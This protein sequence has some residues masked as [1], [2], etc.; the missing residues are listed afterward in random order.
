MST[1]RKLAELLDAATT[2]VPAGHLAPPLAAIHGRVR[3]RRRMFGAVAAAA[4]AVVLAGGYSVGQRMLAEPAPRVPVHPAASP[5]AASAP[6]V[7]WVSAM[8]ARDDT[9][10]T[11][12]AG[13]KQCA[14]LDQPQAR[15]TAQDAAR[16]TIEVTGRTVPAGDCSTSGRAVPIVVTL[17]EPLGERKVV[18]AV[19]LRSHPTYFERFLP[20]LRSDGPWS[21]FDGSW[22][23]DDANWYRGYN[24]PGGSTLHLRAQPPASVRQRAPVT[25]VALGPYEGTITGNSAGMWTVSWQAAGATYSLQLVPNEGE[26]LTLTKFKQEL[27]RLWT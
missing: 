2:D 10:I 19:S 12:Y 17:P 16:V 9:A 13:A 27:A 15:I 20:D 25:T 14:E 23:S 18:D 4:V 24:G 3:R 22:Q 1:D 26:S 21:P 5:T 6:A 11:V 8:V 7:P